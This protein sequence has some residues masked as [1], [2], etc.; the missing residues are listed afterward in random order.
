MTGYY[1]PELTAFNKKGIERYPIYSNPEKYK[2]EN[3]SQKTREEINKGAL[4]NK[5]LE[6]AWAE[7]E[8][9]VFFLHV[10]GSGRLK[11]ENGE[12]KKVRYASNN[13]KAYT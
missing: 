11:M 12:I 13:N 9:E 8:I 6:I 5:G 10:Q 3:L 2:M 1:E 4:A 7:S